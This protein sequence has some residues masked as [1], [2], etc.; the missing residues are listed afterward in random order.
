MSHKTKMHLTS[1]KNCSSRT[2]FNCICACSAL[3]VMHGMVENWLQAQI[4]TTQLSWL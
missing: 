3:F 2:L 1:I 4:I